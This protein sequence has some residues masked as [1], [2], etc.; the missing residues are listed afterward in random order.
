MEITSIA[1]EHG[2]ANDMKGESGAAE[3]DSMQKGADS[4]LKC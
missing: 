3:A 2:T 1:I 4:N